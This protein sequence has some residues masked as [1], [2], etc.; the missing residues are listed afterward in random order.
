MKKFFRRLKK[1]KNKG[2]IKIPLNSFEKEKNFKKLTPN[3]SF[4][5]SRFI[6]LITLLV[7]VAALIGG[8][9]GKFL[10]FYIFEERV[11]EPIDVHIKDEGLSRGEAVA[12]KAAPC[13]VGVSCHFV[14]ED[15]KK[16]GFPYSFPF[17]PFD[18]ENFED[19]KKGKNK[20]YDLRDMEIGS[21]VIYQ[22][23]DDF[24]YI[25]TNFHVVKHSL[26]NGDTSE[27]RIHQGTDLEDYMLANV[28]GY[29]S[30]IDIAV[31]KVPLNGKKL[32]CAEIGDSDKLRHGQEIFCIGSPRG[33]EYNKTIT[34]G[35]IGALK[36]PIKVERIK[37]KIETFQI[38]ASINNGNSGGGTFDCSGKLVGIPFV[39]L[40]SAASSIKKG[41]FT[42]G[43]GFCLPIN[44]VIEKVK[45]I[46]DN[47]GGKT[48]KKIPILGVV[49]RDEDQY[50]YAIK[51][52]LNNKKF[53]GVV[54]DS[55][56]KGSVAEKFGIEAGD[57]ICEFDG[58][59]IETY[60]DLDNAIINRRNNSAAENNRDVSIVTVWHPDIKSRTYKKINITVDFNS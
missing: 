33:I 57:V 12:L 3:V 1:N 11:R 24:A 58:E 9:I 10:D 40:S 27:I 5:R 25:I 43:I 41:M 56:L 26:K 35:I 2:N 50:F 37:D 30:S 59:K 8:I 44:M 38:S 32:C 22:I 28:L 36:R 23:K 15:T 31:L 14:S 18:D 54:V 60:E 21:G 47:S 48:I 45:K 46:M 17:F 4:K 19:N 6:V 49:L 20:D 51:K 13:I 7:F 53:Y 29:D 55:V 42:E 39:K 52:F 34:Q 16:R